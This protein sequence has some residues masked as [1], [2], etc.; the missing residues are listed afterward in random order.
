MSEKKYVVGVDL[1]GTNA[2]AAVVEEAT[3]KIVARSANVPSRA[4]DGV[5]AT[6]RQVV[7]AVMQAIA[8]GEINKDAVRG[9]GMAVPGHVHADD[10]QVLWAPNFKDQWR[11]VQVSKPVADGT[12]L[13]VFLGNDANLAALG[14]YQYG[15]G[16]GYKHLVLFTLGTGVGGGVIIDGN[17]LTGC[18][19]GAGELG[20][21]IVAAGENARGGNTVFGSIEGLAQRDAITDRAARKIAMG[22]K[23]ILVGDSYERHSLTPKAISDAALKGDQV[24]IDVLEE[25]GYYIG[26]G[27][28]SCINIFNPEIFVIGGGIAQA[29]NL[30]F[31]SIRRTTKANSIVTLYE[32]CKIVGAELGDNAGIMGGAALVSHELKKRTK[33]ES[34]S[35]LTK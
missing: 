8:N 14:E 11:S 6:A 3:G 21:I 4:L 19:G 15:A 9:I 32:K 31:D 34:P 24:A 10:G 35:L 28:A 29:G 27:V 33:P 26:L 20:H 12:G 17:L 18:D 5:D 23:S 16:K 1:G 13:P 25:T 7:E 2:R 22:R 30:L